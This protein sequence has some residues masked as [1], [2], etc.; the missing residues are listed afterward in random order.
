MKRTLLAAILS[1]VVLPAIPSTAAAS[2]IES[3]CLRSDRPQATRAL[4]R[5]IGSV[6]NE[7]LTRSEQR[8]AAAFFR[9]PQLAQDV[10]MS[11]SDRDNA[12]WARYRAFGDRAEHFCTGR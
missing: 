5:C 1:A 9:D 4:C 10:R 11:K 2:A 12:F 7:T 3:A 8:R 6:A